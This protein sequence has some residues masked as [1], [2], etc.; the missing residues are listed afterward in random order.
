MNTKSINELSIDKDL[1]KNIVA[2]KR[3]RIIEKGFEQ[4]Q[5]ELEN[6]MDNELIKIESNDSINL[7]KIDISRIN[8]LK[9]DD[10]E[11]DLNYRIRINSMKPLYCGKAYFN[12]TRFFD[13]DWHSSLVKIIENEIPKNEF[14]IDKNNLIEKLE[15]NILKTEAFHP[16]Y[17]KFIAIDKRIFLEDVFIILND[18][19]YTLKYKINSISSFSSSLI[20]FK[21]TSS[22]CS[23]GIDL[24]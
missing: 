1:L 9:K 18:K 4:L 23:Y 7:D 6:L 19:L 8:R 12:E 10:Y 16:V 17:I 21:I 24:I 13:I 14:Y 5:S 11:T 2:E 20:E 22:S 15:L 3:K